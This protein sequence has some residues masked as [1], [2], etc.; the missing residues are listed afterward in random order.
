MKKIILSILYEGWRN[1]ARVIL[2][3]FY[4]KIRLIGKDNLEA[5]R[6]SIIIGNHPATLVDPL[7]VGIHFKNQ[8]YFLANGGLFKTKIG[9]WFFS[10]FYCFPVY[11]RE[12]VAKG[13][14][15]DTQKSLDLSEIHLL[16]NGVLY[17]APEGTSENTLYIRP[18]RTGIARIILKMAK[19]DQPLPDIIPVFCHYFNPQRWTEDIVVIYGDPI[20][21]KKF[22]PTEVSDSEAMKQF[23]AALENY[24]H[25]FGLP[26][27][28]K[29]MD[30]NFRILDALIQARSP[31]EPIKRYERTKKIAK[32]FSLLEENEPSV[33][34]NLKKEIDTLQNSQNAE[35]LGWSMSN[36]RISIL[37]LLW[38]LPILLL[39][40]PIF[41]VI[42]TV[43]NKLKPDYVYHVSF[44]VM[45]T[46]LL[47]PIW[48]IGL[49]WILFHSMGWVGMM[50]FLPIILFTKSAWKVF[51][52]WKL[53]RQ[54]IGV[55]LS[56]RSQEWISA[57]I[58]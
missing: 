41:L 10:T 7:N 14:K 55:K 31:L 20:S 12:D 3:S 46:L 47:A 23:T 51:R 56:N 21:A 40:L 4:G 25:K 34:G 19:A 2:F 27:D 50:V 29:E 39:S 9:N 16:N 45:G 30:T 54:S 26:F 33:W 8:L 11:R 57:W 38:S 18:L 6:G 36:R 1:I 15:G 44:K 5:K 22:W 58:N 28:S 32:A 37:N 43:I 49:G 24:F 42:S 48:Y 53:Q 13:N 52:K 17:V 35:I